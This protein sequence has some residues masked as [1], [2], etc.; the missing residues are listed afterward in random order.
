MASLDQS[1][2]FTHYTAGVNLAGWLSQYLAYDHS[3]FKSFITEQD[4]Q[5]IGGW[6]MDHVRLPVDYPVLEADDQPFHYLDSGLDYLDQCLAWCKRAGLAL[7]IDLHKAPGYNFADFTASTLFNDSEHQERFLA[8]WVALAHRYKNEGDSLTF[9]LLNEI[10]L[11]DSRPWNLLAQRAIQ[12]IRSVDEQRTIILG[13]NYYNSIAGLSGLE[14][15][16][17]PHLVYTFHFYEPMVVTHQKAPWVEPLKVFNQPVGYPGVCENLGDFLRL[18]P[19]FQPFLQS[20]AGIKLDKEYLRRLVQ[21]ALEFRTRAGQPLYCGE[22][23]VIDRASTATRLNWHR[24]FI[25]LL[26]EYRIPRAC[27][28]YKA[29]DFGLVDLHG[30][31]IDQHIVNIVSTH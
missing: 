6:G 14:L 20:Y 12:A 13:G 2:F 15:Y 24:D 25:D 22:Y 27:W 29:M 1:Q 30:Q 3:H 8:L 16:R 28:S 21:P 23:G 4:I 18:H 10:V 7:I 5:R 19:D 11:P 26:R 17:D 9:E 31:V